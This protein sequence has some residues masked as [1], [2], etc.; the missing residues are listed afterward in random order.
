MHAVVDLETL[1]TD[2]NAVI[3]SAGIVMFDPHTVNTI[4]ELDDEDRTLY[5][6]PDMGEQ[7]D[8][9][10]KI[11]VNTIQ[12]WFDQTVM[13]RKVFS[14][15]IIREGS[16]TVC[17]KIERFVRRK[18]V[19]KLWGYGNMFDNAILRSYFNDANATYPLGYRDDLDLR[20]LEEVAGSRIYDLN[21]ERGTEH[22]AYQDALW[23]AVAIQLL[24]QR[25]GLRNLR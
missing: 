24:Y 4:E 25:I 19:T 8:R 3:V 10:R 18:G 1:S 13:A 23:E 7:M 16:E 17:K 9:G 11:D 2:T 21:I 20:T 6:F 14:P 15:T 22:D 5:L 12:W